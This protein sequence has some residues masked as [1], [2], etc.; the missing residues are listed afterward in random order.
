MEV[1][2]S[3]QLKVGLF[4]AIGLTVFAISLLFMGEDQSLFKSTY[5]L[6][7]RF[8]HAQGL[9]PGS[10]VTVSGIRCGSIKRLTFD[11]EGNG[12]IVDL[13]ITTDFKSRITQGSK[14]MVKTLGALGDRYVYIEP[15][16][17]ASPPHANGDFLLSE[18]ADDFLDRLAK[19]GDQLSAVVDVIHEL[20]VLLKNLNGDDRSKK[21]AENLAG[22]TAEIKRLTTEL[23]AALTHGQVDGAS[24][25]QLRDVVQHMQSILR[26]MDR[27]EGTLGALINDPT[28]HQ[29]LTNLVGESPRKGFLK[30]LVRETIQHKDRQ[31]QSASD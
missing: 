3:E 21:I 31:T 4:V 13:E 11:P 10:T 1:S 8:E 7:V 16:D 18:G 27:G 28:L 6:R 12:V 30:P 22:A 20:H 26:K 5:T 25:N 17:R 19:N 15:S 2:R 9:N 23:R 14:A 29:K 24:Q